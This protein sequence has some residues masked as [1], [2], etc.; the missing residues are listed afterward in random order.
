[1]TPWDVASLI[2]SLCLRGVRKLDLSHFGLHSSKWPSDAEECF[3]RLPPQ[4]LAGLTNLRLNGANLD[5]MAMV[6]ILK[7]KPKLKE[8]SI[9]KLFTN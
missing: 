2:E 4:S 5:V 3:S 7:D 6:A 9:G 8:L 1:M